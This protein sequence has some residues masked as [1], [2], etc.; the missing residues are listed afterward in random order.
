MNPL[1]EVLLE[2]EDE[3]RDLKTL[4]MDVSDVCIKRRMGFHKIPNLF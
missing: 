4:N 1:D 2:W 3:L